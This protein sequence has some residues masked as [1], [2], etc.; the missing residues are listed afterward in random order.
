MSLGVAGE[1][2]TTNGA[3]DVSDLRSLHADVRKLMVVIGEFKTQLEKDRAAREA[4]RWAQAPLWLLALA[5]L[6]L[7]LKSWWPG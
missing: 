4:A 2:R 5:S 6:A 1:A 7:A 3:E